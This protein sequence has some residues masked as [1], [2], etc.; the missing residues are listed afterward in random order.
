MMA[1]TCNPRTQEI[2]AD[3]PGVQGHSWLPSKFKASLC[4]VR[5]CLGGEGGAGMES[6]DGGGGGD[7]RNG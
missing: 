2:E 3:R 7:E 1:F 4:Y 6:E 5:L